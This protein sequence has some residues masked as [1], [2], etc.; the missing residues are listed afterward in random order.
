MVVVGGAS[1]SALPVISGVPQGSVLGPLLFL[2]YINDVVGIISPE[3][4]LSLFADDM[5]IYRPIR[6]MQDYSALQLDISV[7]SISQ[8]YPHGST[9][10]I[11]RYSLLSAVPC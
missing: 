7:I 6:S 11:S 9:I 3:S 2:I 5:A 8:S 1:S 10:S 4:S